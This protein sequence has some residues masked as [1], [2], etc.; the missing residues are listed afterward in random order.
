MLAPYLL[1]W[2]HPLSNLLDLAQDLSMLFG[3]NPP[4]Y[5]RPK[6]QPPPPPQAGYPPPQAAYPPPQAAY[7]PP[8][9]AYPPPLPLFTPPPPSPPETPQQGG[10]AQPPPRPDNPAP[11][12][13][14]AF[15]GAAAA[16]L[17]ARLRDS[18]ASLSKAAESRAD[19]QV[20]LRLLLQHRQEQLRE[21]VVALEASRVA[22]ERVS[23][24]LAS[25]GQ[26]LDRHARDAQRECLF[27]FS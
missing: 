22:L 10:G 6:G 17:T 5:A 26:E 2:Q 9:A 19:E 12:L 24:D 1:H 15:R 4:L 18:L 20:S 25:H 27:Y 23:Q 8:Q 3:S 14:E 16:Q 21:E 13:R 11:K 7:P